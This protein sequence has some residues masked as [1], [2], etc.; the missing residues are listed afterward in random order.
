MDIYELKYPMGEAKPPQD[1][2]PQEIESWI[3]EIE[4]LPSI[5]RMV[6]KRLND[7]QLNTSY[8]PD[9]WTL[10]Q[11]IHHM[12]DSHMNAYIRFKLALTEDKPSIRP[13]F[14]DR[15]AELPEAKNGPIELSLSLLESLHKRWVLML[16]QLDH[17]QLKRELFHPE[18]QEIIRLDRMIYTY[19]WHGNHHLAHITMTIEK[20]GWNLRIKDLN[21]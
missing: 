4:D 16:R 2:T 20:K 3:D 12:A 14:E 10:R 7:Q 18:S 21:N 8:R 17:K 15:W 19:A 1:P 11:V 9:G 13:Y 5:L 6:V